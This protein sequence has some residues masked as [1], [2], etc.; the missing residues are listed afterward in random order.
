M[1][2]PQHIPVLPSEILDALSP[3]PGETYVDCTAGLGGHAASIAP[4]LHPGGRVVLNDLDAG[5]LAHATSHT[6]SAGPGVEVTGFHGNFAALPG[7]LV[8]QH[9]RADMVLADLG[10][11]SNQMSDPARGFAFSSDGPLD[12]RLDPSRGMTARELLAT[13]PEAELV[14]ILREY[15]EEKAARPIARKIVAARAEGSISTTGQLAA[16]VRSVVRSGGSI[17]PATRTFQAFRIAVNDELGSLEGLLAAVERAARSTGEGWL[18]AGARVAIVSFHS[19]EDRLVKQSFA[20][21]E[22]RG[23]AEMVGEQ[24]TVPSEAEVHDNP[25]SRSAKLRTIRV[26]ANT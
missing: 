5:N 11:A 7:Q 12:M 3:K 16:L 17:N 19:L 20:R 13:L 25:R 15:G 22:Q 18:A 4:Y 6:K 9:V 2:P 10:F 1:N 26:V 8:R 23:L 21:L 14:R 24:P